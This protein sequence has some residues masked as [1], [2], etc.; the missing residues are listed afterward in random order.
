MLN[1]E[2]FPQ[3]L[4]IHCPKLFKDSPLQTIYPMDSWYLSNHDPKTS[5]YRCQGILIEKEEIGENLGLPLSFI[6]NFYR[7][8][9]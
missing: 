5:L 4:S 6:F 9:I 3:E 8:E 1:I 7:P 2:N